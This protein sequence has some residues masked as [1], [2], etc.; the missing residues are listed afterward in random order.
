[1]G[2]LYVNDKLIIDAHELIETFA[3][4]SGPG[5]QHVNKT[6]TKV[7]LRWNPSSSKSLQS[8][9]RSIVQTIFK[10]I[11]P[12]LSKDGFL[13]VQASSHRSQKRN[14]EMARNKL[15]KIVARA[16][17]AP[18]FRKPT[19]PTRSKIEKRLKEKRVRSEQK[20]ER[21]WKKDTE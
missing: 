12:H 15:A 6:E 17:I 7:E 9:S 2:N 4:S 3:R 16:F 14:R 19:R 1:M 10:N 21:Q 13:I 5:G 11:A 18:N 8:M 20:R